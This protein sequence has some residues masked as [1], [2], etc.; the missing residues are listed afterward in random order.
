MTTP[1]IAAAAE[2]WSRLRRANALKFGILL[3]T[4]SF[5]LIADRETLGSRQI[6][7]QIRNCDHS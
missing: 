4:P 7:N 5:G 3:T 2:H 1:P 6:I